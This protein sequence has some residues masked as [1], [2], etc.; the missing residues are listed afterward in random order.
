MEFKSKKY[1]DVII[2]TIYDITDRLDF[3]DFD[4]SEDNDDN[5]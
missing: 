4:T 3:I 5:I 2:G 1:E